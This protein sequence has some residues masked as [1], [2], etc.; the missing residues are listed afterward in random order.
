MIEIFSVIYP[1]EI[2]GNQFQNWEIIVGTQKLGI[3]KYT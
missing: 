1:P 2:I 3:S